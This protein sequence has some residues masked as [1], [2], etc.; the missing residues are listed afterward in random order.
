[1]VVQARAAWPGSG[2]AEDVEWGWVFGSWSQWDLLVDGCGGIGEGGVRTNDC[3][4]RHYLQMGP[5]PLDGTAIYSIGLISWRK[6]MNHIFY[7]LYFLMI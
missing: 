6:C 4:A 7:Y 2:E 3:R 1:M 5:L